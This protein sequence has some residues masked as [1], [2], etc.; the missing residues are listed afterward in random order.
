MG[1][2]S[3]R[4]CAG[5]TLTP[6][7][8]KCAENRLATRLDGM[9]GKL[10]SRLA[11]HRIEPAERDVLL[12]RHAG[13][14][15][16]QHMHSVD[17][18]VQKFVPVA[19]D[20]RLD[21]MVPPDDAEQ[22]VGIEQAA[23][24]VIE[25]VVKAE[26]GGG[27]AGLGQVLIQPLAL[28]EAQHAGNDIDPI[29]RVEDEESDAWVFDNHD[30]LGRRVTDEGVLAES[31]EEVLA[32]V[33]ITQGEAHWKAFGHTSERGLHG[34]VIFRQAM[35]VSDVSEDH[36]GL[37]QGFQGLLGGEREISGGIVQW[38]AFLGISRKVRV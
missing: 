8:R 18:V 34:G 15:E 31:P 10:P 36:C 13:G 24:V 30:R 21:V 27:P 7:K 25:R 35:P 4:A 14:R 22:A 26:D 38:T 19:V 3:E 2:G 1:E 5:N 9:H 16:L 11:E 6:M 20:D 17:L 32:H 37:R 28:P 23:V 29:G 12:K 33:V